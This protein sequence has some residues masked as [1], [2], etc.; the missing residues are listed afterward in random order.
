M[1]IHK[2]ETSI[3]NEQRKENPCNNMKERR[4]EEKE[5]SITYIYDR[6]GKVQHT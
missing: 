4:D 5:K 3:D 1:E 2:M 6:E